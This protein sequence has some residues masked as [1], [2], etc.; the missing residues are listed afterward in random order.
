MKNLSDKKIKKIKQETLEALVQK[1]LLYIEALNRGLDKSPEFRN[2]VKGYERNIVFGVFV[3][4]V[5]TPA[6]KINED[7]LRAYYREH[8]SEY[9]SEPRVWIRTIIFGQKDDALSAFEKM[10]KGADMTWIKANAP[11]QVEQ[12]DTIEPA[13]ED[14]PVPLTS[15]AEDIQ[16]ALAGVK[17]D[18]V[19]LYASQQGQYHILYVKELIPP[20][21]LTFDQVRQS[22]GPKVYNI[23]LNKAVEDWTR[24][25]KQAADIKI[26]LTDSGK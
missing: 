22:L 1:R 21:Q 5:V 16:S 10:K 15:L 23:N 26:Y 18:E 7:D 6:V 8:A 3:Q 9:K 12:S 2:M 14:Q 17:A 20:R 11:G 13:F 24:K 25:L 19:R 4:Q